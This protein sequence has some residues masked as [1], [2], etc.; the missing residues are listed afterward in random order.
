MIASDTLY[1]IHLI[2][3]AIHRVTPNVKKTEVSWQWL[4]EM[5]KFQMLSATIFP[6]LQDMKQ[7]SKLDMPEEIWIAWQEEYQKALVKELTFD[8][9]RSEILSRFDEMRIPYLP[10]KGVYLKNEYPKAGMRMFSDNDILID[11]TRAVEVQRIM[12]GLGYQGAISPLSCQ[13]VYQKPP[14]LNFEMHSSLF[15][16]QSPYH[17]YFSDIFS[18]AKPTLGSGFELSHEDFYLYFLAHFHKHYGGGGCGVRGLVDNYLYLKNHREEMDWDYLNT[19]LAELKLSDFF[20]KMDALSQKLFSP[21]PQLSSEETK[22]L[23]RM[24]SCGAYGK[25]S[26]YL[27]QRYEK[28]TQKGISYLIRRLL[29]S[30]AS[31]SLRMPM[32]RKYPILFIPLYLPLLARRCAVAVTRISFVREEIYYVM[33]HRD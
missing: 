7:N 2:A 21:N 27:E 32:L 12:N 9:A 10:L 23:H 18:R 1:F 4:F 17:I 5:A 31:A 25:Y 33:K 28:S 20:K 15:A 16:P 14:T 8:R 24:M 13:D 30:Y 11:G 22:I 3:C 26:H 19:Q 29:P 6:A